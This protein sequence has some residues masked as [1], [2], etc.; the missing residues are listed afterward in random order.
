MTWQN[1][2]SLKKK[3]GQHFLCDEHFID[4]MLAQV[5]LTPDTNVFEIGGGAGALTRAILRQPVKQ[6]WTFEIDPEWAQELKKIDDPRLVIYNQDFLTTNFEIFRPDAP[7]IL[8]ANLP[9][10]ISFPILYR[11]HEY[12]ELVREGVIMLQEEVAQKI[13]KTHGRGYGFNSL[14]LQYYFEWKLLEKVPPQ[15]FNPPPHVFSRLLYFKPKSNVVAIDD[16]TRFW[17]FIRVCFAQ[18]RRTLRN[19]LVPTEYNYSRLD[20][21]T[22]GLRAQ[23]MTIA[24]FLQI[25]QVLK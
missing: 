7:W 14:F 24:D 6:L 12:R 20:E 2:I 19:N 3:F 13:V 23:Q 9:Y 15:A 11:L 18:P 22:L 16:E 4:V 17:K 21:H 1:N 8:L 5:H 10:Q 25:W